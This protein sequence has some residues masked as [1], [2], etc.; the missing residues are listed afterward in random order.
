M[1]VTLAIIVGGLGALARAE[2]AELVTRAWGR[3]GPW[4]TFAVNIIGSFVLGVVV[5][6]LDVNGRAILGTG[7]CG[8]FTVYATFAFETVQQIDRGG[9]AAAVVNVLGSVVLGTAA[10]IAGIAIPGAW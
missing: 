6:N 2:L 5:S 1:I 9:R 8:G 4:A 10:A 3:R 7:F